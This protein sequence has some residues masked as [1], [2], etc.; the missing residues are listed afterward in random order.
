MAPFY[1]GMIGGIIIDMRRV[2]TRCKVC[3]YYTY[4]LYK[5][6]SGNFNWNKIG[7]RIYV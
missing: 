3:I 4:I 2:E 1:S 7:G 6:I 5:E